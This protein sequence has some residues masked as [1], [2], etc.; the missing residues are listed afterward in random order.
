MKIQLISNQ[1]TQ[2][3]TKAGKPYNFIELAF[4]NLST[5]KVE[6]KK[7][8][9]FG[10]TKNTFDALSMGSAGDVYEITT[11]KNAGTGYWDWTA[12]TRTTADAGSPT[13]TATRA[14]GASVSPKST[15]ETPEERAVKQIYIVRQSSISNAVA[16]LSPGSKSA[17]DVDAV[18]AVANRLEDYVFGK[19]KQVEAVSQPAQTLSD[20]DDDIPF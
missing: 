16:I 4:K 20:M 10:E 18:L 19:D 6:G 5:G 9:P 3:M 14:S 8:M 2:A 1:Q 15:Y 13:P 17:L 12:A 11:V 7:L